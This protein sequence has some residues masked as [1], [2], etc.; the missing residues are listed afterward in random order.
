MM[1]GI[2]LY[3]EG[4]SLSERM[5]LVLFFGHGIECKAIGYL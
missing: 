1:I 4:A 3:N 5:G 2:L